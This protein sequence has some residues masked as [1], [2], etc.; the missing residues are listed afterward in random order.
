VLYTKIYPLIYPDKKDK[1]LSKIKRMYIQTVNIIIIQLSK[2]RFR[3]FYG[4]EV[5]CPKSFSLKKPRNF[6]NKQENEFFESNSH[7]F[8]KFSNNNWFYISLS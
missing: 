7:N 1:N 3:N 6:E 5:I 4:L 8:H 2:Q